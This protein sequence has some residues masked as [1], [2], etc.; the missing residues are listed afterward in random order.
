MFDQFVCLKL[1]NQRL[2]DDFV[3]LLVGDNYLKSAE[4]FVSYLILVDYIPL[5][6]KK[7]KFIAADTLQEVQVPVISTAECRKRTVFLPLYKITDDMFCAGYER[8]GRDACLGDSGGPLMCPETNGRWILQGK[9]NRLI[10]KYDYLI[11]IEFR[12]HQ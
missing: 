3:R 1:D 12:N 9:I 7:Y 11:L 2:M 4:Y 6:D 8:G 10:D 5:N